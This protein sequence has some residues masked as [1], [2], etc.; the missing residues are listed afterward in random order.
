MKKKEFF[1]FPSSHF[2][3]SY[4]VTII[5]IRREKE[6]ERKREKKLI[7]ENF[8]AIEKSVEEI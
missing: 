5:N 3:C 4:S 2:I 6:R 1:N 7:I 8:K